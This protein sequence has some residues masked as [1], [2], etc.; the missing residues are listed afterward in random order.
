VRQ[1]FSTIAADFRGY[2]GKQLKQNFILDL[3]RTKAVFNSTYLTEEMHF[4]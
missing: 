1:E 2:F 4:A 3:R